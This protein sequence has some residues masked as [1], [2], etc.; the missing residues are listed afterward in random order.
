[1][2]PT[3]YWTLLAVSCGYALLRGRKY[4]R[5]TAI[6]CIVASIV[7]VLLRAPLHERYLGVEAG[8]LLV[9]LLVLSAFVAIALQSDRFWP[10]WVA[11]LQLTTSMGHMV[12]AV[13]SD[14]LP[15]AYAAALRFWAYPIL[16][17]LLVGTWRSRQRALKESRSTAPI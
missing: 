16:I 17:I 11:G 12:K 14:L 2:S 1:M 15:L 13:H 6:I 4:E 8:D 7:S 5:L 3:L 10:L 9:D